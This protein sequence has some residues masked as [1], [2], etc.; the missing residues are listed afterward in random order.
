[1]WAIE[2]GR[3]ANGRG[4][5]HVFGGLGRD[6]PGTQVTPLFIS[7]IIFERTTLE[8]TLLASKSHGRLSQVPHTQ[9]H[10]HRAVETVPPKGKDKKSS[11]SSCPQCFEDP[12]PPVGGRTWVQMVPFMQVSALCLGSHA[13]SAYRVTAWLPV[14]LRVFTW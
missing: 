2:G 9:D 8:F 4:V 12:E 5:S 14:S 11:V 1:M 7:F 3:S 13:Q 10:F 6:L